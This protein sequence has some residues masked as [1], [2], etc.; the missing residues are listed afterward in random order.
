[1]L[2]AFVLF[3]VQERQRDSLEHFKFH[4]IQPP[5]AARHA[6]QSQLR[7]DLL[8]IEAEPGH[9]AHA[10]DNEAP[11]QLPMRS[12]QRNR[13]NVVVV[14]LE[15]LGAFCSC[16]CASLTTIASAVMFGHWLN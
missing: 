11:V 4:A 14:N 12:Q 16:A 1:M 7:L 15:Q 6:E 9:A 10:A 5:A 2:G 8:P 3:G 13:R